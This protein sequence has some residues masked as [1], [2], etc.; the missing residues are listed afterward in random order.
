[1]C[2]P[3]GI[4]EQDFALYLPW[5][6]F[7]P[8]FWLCSTMHSL[9][10]KHRTLPA[11]YHPKVSRL[12]GGREDNHKEKRLSRKLVRSIKRWAASVMTAR[13][14]AMCPPVRCTILHTVEGPE[15]SSAQMLITHC[16]LTQL[17]KRKKKQSKSN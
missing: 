5:L 11:R 10:H 1:M 16:W 15:C 3:V 4:F 8:L 17:G 14:P 7:S 2:G 9:S 13:L 12:E 6:F